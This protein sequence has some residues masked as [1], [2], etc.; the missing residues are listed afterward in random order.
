MNDPLD[1]LTLLAC[2]M[3]EQSDEVR[4]MEAV[5][6]LTAERRALATVTESLTLALDDL[7]A[8]KDDLRKWQYLARELSAAI[9]YALLH[10]CGG[11]GESASR[12]RTALADYGERLTK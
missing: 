11:E 12:L 1:N 9:A 5:G 2:T 3:P 4:I 6:A 7:S 8:T 10:G